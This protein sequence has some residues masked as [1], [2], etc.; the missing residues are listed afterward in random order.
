MML[1]WMNQRIKMKAMLKFLV[2][3]FGIIKSK[4]QITEIKR[5]IKSKLELEPMIAQEIRKNQLWK[6]SIIL[7]DFLT[8]HHTKLSLI[9]Q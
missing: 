8:T 7:E 2:G 9:T 1:I 6:I 3:L 5:R 4:F